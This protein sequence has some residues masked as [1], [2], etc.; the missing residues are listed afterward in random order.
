VAGLPL[1]EVDGVRV[2]QAE[3]EGPL[4]ASLLFR[5]GQ[6]D[7]TLAKRGITHLIEH[8]ALTGTAR[9][10][11]AFNG[12]TGDLLT[13]FVVAG[14][15]GEVAAHLGAVCQALRALP[16]ERLTHERGV[17][18][19]EAAQSGG[20][21]A[22]SLLT[23]RWGAEGYGLMGWDE[24]GVPALTES[25]VAS[26]AAERFVRDNAV[27]WISGEI[28]AGLSLDLP[29]RPAGVA[30]PSEPSLEPA[31]VLPA[32]Y[33]FS[34][35]GCAFSYLAPRVAAGTS[36]LY[37][38]QRRL[39]TKLRDE[40][41]ASYGVQ[42]G[43]ERISAGT[44]M[45]VFGADCLPE[46]A[47]AVQRGVTDVL[48]QLLDEPATQAEI[49]DM[50]SMIRL[51]RQDRTNSTLAHLDFVARQL[52][53]G[54]EVRTADELSREQ[55]EVTSDDIRALAESALPTLLLAVPEAGLVPASLATPAPLWSTE[56]VD[57]AEF[58][59]TTT[60]GAKP[61]DSLVVGQH[62]VSRLSDGNVVTVEF[63]RCVAMIR[64]DDGA[65]TLIGAD[66][67]YVPFVPEEW[68]S[69][70]HVTALLDGAV[71]ADR[72]IPGGPRT[73]A[74]PAP[75]P[76]A[77]KKRTWLQRAGAVWLA[78]AALSAAGRLAT[79]GSTTSSSDADTT[80]NGL[81]P[82]SIVAVA[83]GQ[84]LDSGLLIESGIA[85]P[86]PCPGPHL[87]EV[88]SVISTRGADA[89]HRMSRCQEDARRLL[90]EA[91]LG[92]VTISATPIGNPATNGTTACIATARI[93]NLQSAL[94][95]R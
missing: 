2:L 78:V 71:P 32:A 42:A 40:L 74:A 8:L 17:L 85:D 94:S 6:A 77:P 50:R 24:L 95:R 84:C 68:T 19:T 33:T 15:P 4:R 23:W 31:I 39:Q 20:R 67:F 62:G 83:P 27:L 75:A 89:P 92:Q 52:L 57:G 54:G 82:P 9:G 48:Q 41:G 43:L 72:W 90:T 58:S 44:S 64:Y 60:S 10:P 1:T 69:A 46:N 88:L 11:H 45:H 7:E 91:S 79:V 21:F 87:I 65:R 12:F 29:A 3:A 70:T 14:E 63:D 13:A 36:L 81:T 53:V 73:S 34:D 22:R 26:W 49:D 38:V 35:R 66:G 37:L 86:V 93:G 51:A 28:P 59:R 30:A 16:M 61:T 5:V 47:T 56:R 25:A 18:D 55:E 76:P 80:G